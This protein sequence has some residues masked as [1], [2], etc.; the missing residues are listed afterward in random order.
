M[1]ILLGMKPSI[2]LYLL[3]LINICGIVT[4]MESESCLYLAEISNK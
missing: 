2:C 3:D 4:Y 1:S